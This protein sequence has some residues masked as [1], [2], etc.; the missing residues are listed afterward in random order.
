MTALLMLALQYGHLSL[1]EALVRMGTN[2]NALN[3]VG[4]I[5]HKVLRRKQYGLV[6]LL[7][8]HGVDVNADEVDGETTLQALCRHEDVPVQVLEQLVEY[9]ARVTAR[10]H[11]NGAIPFIGLGFTIATPWQMC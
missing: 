8:D 7:L 5:L 10:M 4:P 9:G 2:V 3:S 11:P 1:F 6:K